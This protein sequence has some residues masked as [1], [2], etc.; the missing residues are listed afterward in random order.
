MD[1]F[2][3][4]KLSTVFEIPCSKV[5]ERFAAEN[6]DYFSIWNVFE[7]KTISLNSRQS[8]EFD[9]FKIFRKKIQKLVQNWE[10]GEVFF[11]RRRFHLMR[12]S[13][14]KVRAIEQF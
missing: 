13:E 14:L 8:A 10:I 12:Q 2:R 11:L 9:E 5:N 6:C 3:F 1:I 7:T 4:Q